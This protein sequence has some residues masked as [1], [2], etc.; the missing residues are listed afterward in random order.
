MFVEST[1]VTG[2][3]PSCRGGAR[4]F[5][6]A[7]DVTGFTGFTGATEVTGFTGVYP[8]CGRGVAAWQQVGAQ[9]FAA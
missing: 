7:T 6:G 2:V 4:G 8:S 1:Q 9:F 5:T 3:Y